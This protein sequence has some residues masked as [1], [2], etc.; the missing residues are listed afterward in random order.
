MIILA[1]WAFLIVIASGAWW[2]WT[3]MLKRMGRWE[4]E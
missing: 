4:S 2:A 1:I 3:D